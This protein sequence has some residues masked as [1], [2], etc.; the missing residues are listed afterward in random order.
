MKLFLQHRALS[1]RMTITG[2]RVIQMAV[3]QAVIKEIRN[4]SAV[5]SSILRSLY[6]RDGLFAKYFLAGGDNWLFKE[7]NKPI[8]GVENGPYIQ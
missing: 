8:P 7:I 4:K 3:K 6:H 2:K 5:I 1:E